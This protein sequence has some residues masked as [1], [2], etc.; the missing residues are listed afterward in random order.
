M[1]LESAGRAWL[2]EVVRNLGV[3]WWVCGGCVAMWLGWR[4]SRLV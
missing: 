1:F 2:C 3:G 4:R